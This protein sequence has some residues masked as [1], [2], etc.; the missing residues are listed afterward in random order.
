[1]AVAQQCTTHRLDKPIAI[2]SSRAH[3]AGGFPIPPAYTTRSAKLQYIIGSISDL[4]E[5]LVA[6]E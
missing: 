2:R 3:V 6:R 4:A 1:M 5:R